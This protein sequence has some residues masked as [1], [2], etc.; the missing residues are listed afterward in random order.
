MPLTAQ[1]GSTLRLSAHCN[2]LLHA[3]VTG[4]AQ[5]SQSALDKFVQHINMGPSAAE[6]SKVE[7]KDIATKNDET[8]F[9]Q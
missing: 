8:K 2:C 9:T 4:E 1:Y 5:G 6:V 3:Q 7:Q